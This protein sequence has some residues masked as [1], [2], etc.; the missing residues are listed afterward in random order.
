MNNAVIFE[1]PSPAVNTAA[2]W[3]FNGDLYSSDKD[4][5]T[6]GENGTIPFSATASPNGNVNCA[7]PFSDANYGSFPSSLESAIVG[8]TDILIECLAYFNSV[9][10]LPVLWQMTLNGAITWSQ[11]DVGG[12]IKIQS[13]AGIVA[14]AAGVVAATT[15]YYIATKID[16]TAGNEEIYVSTAPGA[17]S[18]T[19][20]ATGNIAIST[21]TVAGGVVGRYVGAGGFY[22]NGVLSDFRVTLGTRATLP[23]L[24]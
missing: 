21:A 10:N 11:I 20:V 15:W 8:E 23:T 19:P 12:K 9:A 1:R 3:R 5:R 14:S 24:L 7:G 13:G 6:L 22:V 18:Q 4:R 17:V 16:T 2:L